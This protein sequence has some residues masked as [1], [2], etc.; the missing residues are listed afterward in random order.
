MCVCAYI[1]ICIIVNYIYTLFTFS[2]ML[3]TILTN[4]KIVLKQV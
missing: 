4:I 2:I 1:Y 3:F